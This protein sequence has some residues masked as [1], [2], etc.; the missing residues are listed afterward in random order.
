MRLRDLEPADSTATAALHLEVLHME[1]IARCGPAFLRRYHRAWVASPG[2]IGLAAENEEGVV[3][4]VLLGATD[5]A[6]H[7]SAMVADHG[8]AL[9]ALLV[10]AALRNPKLA[11]ELLATRTSRYVGGVYR[12]LRRRA[13]P[14]GVARQAAAVPGAQ[15]ATAAATRTGEVT[16]LLVAPAAQGQGVGR[17]LIEATAAQAAA[18]GVG[19]LVLVTPPEL[20]ARRFYE[21][22]GWEAAG[23]VTSKSGEAFV[24]FRLALD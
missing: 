23:E 12:A 1:F 24:R 21:R 11:R 22:M 9:G 14:G 18:A 10:S 3:V 2:A 16:H 13:R 19:E 5:P 8:L 4:G 7:T 15:P 17:A 6:A 20:E